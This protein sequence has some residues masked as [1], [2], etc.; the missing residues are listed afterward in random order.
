M[1]WTIRPY[2]RREDA[3]AMRHVRKWSVK[4]SHHQ[5]PQC[6]ENHSIPA[7]IFSTAGY[8]GNHF[9]EFSDIIIPLFLKNQ[10]S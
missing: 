10:Y 7:V 5:V 2:A 6:T 3:Y 4:A 1:S 8:T 9:H